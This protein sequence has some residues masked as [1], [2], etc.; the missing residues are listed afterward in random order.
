[1]SSNVPMNKNIPATSAEVRDKFLKF[2]Q[3]GPSVEEARAA[4]LNAREAAATTAGGV[5]VPKFI[6]EESNRGMGRGGN[7]PV[8]QNT[9]AIKH[10]ELLASARQ[11]IAK[12]RIPQGKRVNLDKMRDAGLITQ[13]EIDA[14]LLDSEGKAPK[15]ESE[16]SEEVIASIVEP[17][18]TPPAVERVPATPIEA[19]APVVE[20]VV[21]PPAPEPD[22][23]KTIETK[24]FKGR[25][26]KDGKEWVAEITYNN[27]SGSERFSASNKDELMLKLL[28]GKGHGTVK[29]RETVQ[30]YK[31]GDTPDDWNYF[32]KQMK[33]SHGLTIEQFNALPEASRDSIQDTI[34]AAEAMTFQENYP[35]YYN[36]DSNWQ[37][38]VKFL[39]SRKWPL[40]VHNLEL[41]YRELTDED[42]LE[43]RPAPVVKTVETHSA[44]AAPQVSAPASTPAPVDSAAAATSTATPAPAAPAAVPVV[45]TVRKRVSTGLIPGSSSAAP[46][47]A[48]PQR[49]E[50]GRKLEEPSEIELRRAAKDDI[51]AYKR[52]WITPARKFGVRY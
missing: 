16:P 28:E 33:D 45:P 29:V 23:S 37:Q 38:L 20:V 1:M 14:L 42:L 52:Q 11:K 10:A 41:A 21:P 43:S 31:V 24:K 34:Q 15:E 27:G 36:V 49:T 18:E 44:P 47:T 50:E 19:P 13:P 48:P 2:K 32:F 7:T 17:E 51:S 3:G 35:E 9:A 25:L 6:E 46:E 8:V 12:I 4:M 5:K 40:T 30:R 39:S 22:S 26:F